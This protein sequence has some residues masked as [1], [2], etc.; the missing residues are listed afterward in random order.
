MASSFQIQ[1]K[2]FASWLLVGGLVFGAMALLWSAVAVLRHS[3]RSMQLSAILLLAAWI[4]G[5]IDALVH[6]KDAWASMPAATILSV[7]ALLL[8]TVAIAAGIGA[9]RAG[10]PR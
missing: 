4:V 3:A 2:N 8:V 10:D 9:G 1:W 7:I 6:A 5:F